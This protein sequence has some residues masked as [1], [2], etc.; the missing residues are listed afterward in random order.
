[1]DATNQSGVEAD[2]MQLVQKWE[3]MEPMQSE[4]KRG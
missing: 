4:R 2:S 1:M 3:N